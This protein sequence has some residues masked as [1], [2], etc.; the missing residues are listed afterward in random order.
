MVFLNLPNSFSTNFGTALIAPSIVSYWNVHGHEEHEQSDVL[1]TIRSSADVNW[2]IFG[3]SSGPNSW[4]RIFSS[5]WSASLTSEITLRTGDDK[6]V[7]EAETLCDGLNGGVTPRLLSTADLELS[8]LITGRI[9]PRLPGKL[10]S[11]SVAVAST[12]TVPTTVSSCTM[13]ASSTAWDWG[14]TNVLP[15]VDGTVA[16]C[17]HTENDSSHGSRSKSIYEKTYGVTF[18]WNYVSSPRKI[19]TLSN[20]DRLAIYAAWRSWRDFP[21]VSLCWLWINTEYNSMEL[22][23]WEYGIS[24]SV[25]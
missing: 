5:C 20:S 19:P 11:T 21:T 23:P 3:P 22:D 25:L 10:T 16:R 15:E 14:C 1:C 13:V 12:V 17:C 6:G 7:E 2:C 18:S 8:S 4:R 9:Y 24:T